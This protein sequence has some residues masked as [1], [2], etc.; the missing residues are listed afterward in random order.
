MGSIRPEHTDALWLAPERCPAGTKPTPD[1]LPLG[2]DQGSD[3]CE[4]RA[5]RFQP[6]RFLI[7]RLPAPISNLTALLGSGEFDGVRRNDWP[8]SNRHDRLFSNLSISVEI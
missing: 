4:R 6:H 2:P 5:S 7:A 3:T 8:V 1:R